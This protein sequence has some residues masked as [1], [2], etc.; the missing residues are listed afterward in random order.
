MSVV[1]SVPHAMACSAWARP[2]SPPSEAGLE[3]FDMFCGLKGLTRNPR[4][5]YARHMPA[6]RSDLPTLD[7]VPCTMTA[8]AE[9]A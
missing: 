4:R 3:L 2:I 1:G 7:P 9:G 5:A 8:L 6:T